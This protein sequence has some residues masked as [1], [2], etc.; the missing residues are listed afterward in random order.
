MIE[1]STIVSVLK[2]N[3]LII[4]KEIIKWTSNDNKRLLL[5][6]VFF[7]IGIKII[8]N[9]SIHIFISILKNLIKKSVGK[10]EAIKKI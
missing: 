3:N 2:F 7:K 1:I 4:V 10:N 5:S 9:P 6:I 8:I